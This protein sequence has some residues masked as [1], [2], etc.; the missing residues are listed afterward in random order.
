MQFKL[1]AAIFFAFIV[2]AACTAFVVSAQAQAS[3]Q[4]RNAQGLSAPHQDGR[5]SGMGRVTAELEARQKM[6]DKVVESY[7]GKDQIAAVQAISP[8]AEA[9]AS[10]HSPLAR[11]QHQQ[12]AFVETLTAAARL[13][14]REAETAL[15][16]YGLNPGKVARGGAQPAMGGP[17]IAVQDGDEHLARLGKSLE[18][19]DRMERTLLAIPN[20]APTSPMRLT[21]TF[22]HRSDPFNGRRAVHGG[23]D[24][25]G[26]TGQRI[27]ASA[28]GRVSFAGR[29]SGYGNLIKIDHGHGIETRYGHL[30]KI[31]VRAGQVIARGADIGRMGSTGR[32][33]GPHLHFEVRLDG[34]ALDP[35]QFLEAKPEVIAVQ[36]SAKARRPVNTRG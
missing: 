34:R 33:T 3:N 5:Q 29:A 20:G 17:F 10:E 8:T 16:A 2:G 18:R 23:M 31:S 1:A 9:V 21:S 19:L 25:G 13:R 30:S 26:P 7:F 6:L 14:T 11:L 24:I 35:R 12:I 27:M 28:A 15:R 22:G 32:S 4:S 36:N